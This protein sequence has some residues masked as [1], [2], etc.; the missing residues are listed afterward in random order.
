MI[1][2][3]PLLVIIG[4]HKIGLSTICIIGFLPGRKLACSA[5]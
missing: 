3:A 5:L 4:S 1:G 2:L